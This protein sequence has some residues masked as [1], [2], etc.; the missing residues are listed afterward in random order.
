MIPNDYKENMTNGKD[1]RTPHDTA[2][3]MSPEQ[4]FEHVVQFFNH[5]VL[6]GL[7][8]LRLLMSRSREELRTWH[9]ETLS[10][11]MRL[12]REDLLILLQ[13]WECVYPEGHAKGVWKW[14]KNVLDDLMI[15][16]ARYIVLHREDETHFCR[17]YMNKLYAGRENVPPWVMYSRNSGTVF[18]HHDRHGHGGDH[19]TC[20]IFGRE[21]SLGCYLS[22]DSSEIAVRIVTWEHALT[23]PWAHQMRS[24]ECG[25]MIPMRGVAGDPSQLH[26]SNGGYEVP[27]YWVVPTERI[28][29]NHQGLNANP[30]K[31]IY[32]AGPDFADALKR[33][34]NELGVPVESVEPILPRVLDT[35]DPDE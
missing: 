22:Q 15:R 13:A 9:D 11:N 8:L 3:Y 23:E 24:L 12:F 26:S 2:K 35:D 31:V 21:L 6:C 27:F 18:S 32:V 20:R 30:H 4:A 33:R 29:L 28:R 7:Y 10:P 19:F 25:Y 17:Y 16:N 34:L 5:R 14:A 1:G